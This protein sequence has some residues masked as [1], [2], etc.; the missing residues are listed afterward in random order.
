MNRLYKSRSDKV[1]DGV[2]GG[3]G[4]YLGIDPVII[5]LLWII[6]VIFGGT[7][8]L[9]YLVAMV[10]IPRYPEVEGLEGD[11]VPTNRYSHRF[12]GILLVIAGFMLLL[13]IMGPLRGLFAGVAHVM[14]SVVWPILIIGLGVYLLVHQGGALDLK[15]SLNEVFPEDRKF[16]RSRTDK[17]IAGVCGGIGEYLNIDANIIRVFWTLATLGSLAI[18]VLG[19]LAMAVFIAESD[20][21]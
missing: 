18:G 12:W 8:L 2:C 7:G 6:L 14:G 16:H 20:P 5:R 17:H 1:F 11:A 19:Y 13:G 4:E 9:A 21:S 10:I 15:G 3:I